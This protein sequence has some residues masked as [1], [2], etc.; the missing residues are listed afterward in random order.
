MAQLQTQID[1]LKKML[2][3]KKRLIVGGMY[4]PDS[5]NTII[6]QIKTMNLRLAQYDILDK[7]MVDRSFYVQLQIKF[8]KL[9][10]DIQI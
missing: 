10:F 1:F 5:M 3:H 7:P 2:E 8:D 9:L 6:R 4:Q